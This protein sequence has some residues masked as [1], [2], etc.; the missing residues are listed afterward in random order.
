MDDGAMLGGPCSSRLL[1][2]SE[3]PNKNPAQR[4]K[5]MVN[6]GERIYPSW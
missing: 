1:S 6:C 5:T 2:A 3:Q 4:I